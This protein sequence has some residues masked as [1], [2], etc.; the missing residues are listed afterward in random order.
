GGGFRFSDE[1][2]KWR[3][4]NAGLPPN[5]NIQSIVTNGATLWAATFGDGVYTSNDRGAS[6]RAVN[7]GLANRFVNKLFLSGATLYAG[8]DGGVFRS[9]NGGGGWTA[10]NT[11]LTNQRAVGFT[12]AN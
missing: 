4:G 6:W 1:G 12:L 8:T 10:I 2:E 11:G 7:N 3:E 9:T 5:P